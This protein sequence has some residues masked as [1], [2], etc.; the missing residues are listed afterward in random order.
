[1]KRKCAL[2]CENFLKQFNNLTPDVSGQQFN[3]LAPDISGQQ[4]FNLVIFQSLI[5]KNEF[6]KFKYQ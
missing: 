5:K 6:I 4:S 2:V 1:M 3:N